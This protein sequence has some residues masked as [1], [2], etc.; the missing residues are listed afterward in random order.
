MFVNPES[1]LPLG[2]TVVVVKEVV[3]EYSS[4]GELMSAVLLGST[5]RV[6]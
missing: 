2:F 1:V 6:V 5:V 3:Y 4:V